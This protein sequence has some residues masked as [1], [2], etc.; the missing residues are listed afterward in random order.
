MTAKLESSPASDR[1][2][3]APRPARS[4]NKDRHRRAGLWAVFSFNLHSVLVRFMCNK[5]ITTY[6]TWAEILQFL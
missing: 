2:T 1:R 6:R 4:T 5:Q 3:R